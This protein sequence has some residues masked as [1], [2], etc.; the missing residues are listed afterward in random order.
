MQAP[1]I[2]DEW[3]KGSLLNLGSILL[4]FAGTLVLV[5]MW[6]GRLDERV[7]AQAGLIADMRQEQR[8]LRQQ[9]GTLQWEVRALTA[10]VRASLWPDQRP[11]APTRKM[12]AWQ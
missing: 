9:I 11:T 7:S 4:G 8:E 6:F 5:S 10:E 12:E 1:K 3:S 2:K